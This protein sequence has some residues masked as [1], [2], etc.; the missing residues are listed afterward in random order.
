MWK[1]QCGPRGV[2][3]ELYLGKL[4]VVVEKLF[5]GQEW[6]V[7]ARTGSLAWISG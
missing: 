4:E 2:S 1:L 5:G 6:R 3:G 7:R